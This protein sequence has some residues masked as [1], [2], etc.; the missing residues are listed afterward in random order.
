MVRRSGA[1]SATPSASSELKI[2][3]GNPPVPLRTLGSRKLSPASVIRVGK[4]LWCLGTRER[5]H[6]YPRRCRFPVPSTL[7]CHC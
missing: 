7:T 3:Q 1:T 4:S 5:E 6:Q 2:R